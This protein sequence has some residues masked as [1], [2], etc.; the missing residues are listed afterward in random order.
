[1]F[2]VIIRLCSGPP[3]VSRFH[4][5]LV[6]LSALGERRNRGDGEGLPRE[7]QSNTI[8]QSM[9]HG[10]KVESKE[11]TASGLWEIWFV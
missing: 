4:V 3:I 6:A 5:L 9:C 7:H 8:K 10:P 2:N 1:M 11:L